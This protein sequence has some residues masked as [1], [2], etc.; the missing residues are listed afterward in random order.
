MAGSKVP[1]DL[2]GKMMREQSPESS[3]TLK[4]A[5]FILGFSAWSGFFL[6]ALVTFV[7]KWR[8]PVKDNQNM[9]RHTF[10][11]WA[12][13]PEAAVIPGCCGCIDTLFSISL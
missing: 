5:L 1:I 6:E 11:P 13:L 8:K 7:T 4:D 2:I 9:Q 12:T 10:P 3:Q